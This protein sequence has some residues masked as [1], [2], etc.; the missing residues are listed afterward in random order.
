M[1]A[2][3]VTI[4]SDRNDAQRRMARRHRQAGRP[5]CRTRCRALLAPYLDAVRNL[6]P[7]GTLRVYPGSP[8]LALALIRPQDRLIACELEPRAA[9]ALE[10]VLRD[11]RAKVVAID[12]WTAL[13]AYVPPKERRGVVLVDPPFEQA[14]DF[15]R[16]ASAFGGGAPQM[17]DRHLY[18]VVSD[19]GARRARRPWRGNCAS[20]RCRA[21]CAAR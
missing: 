14:A 4:C 13:G 18:A 5:C 19:Q 6:D 8:L 16:L 9:A 17:A 21:C 20:S 12:G 2:P 3:A 10:G 1:P 15:A 7:G 11:R